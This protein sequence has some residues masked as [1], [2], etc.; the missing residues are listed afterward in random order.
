[1]SQTISLA[2]LC[3][4]KCDMGLEAVRSPRM[5]G[6]RN[7]LKIISFRDEHLDDA[8]AL[9]SNRFTQLRTQ[10]PL[11]PIRYTEASEFLSL[12]RDISTAS[13][14][15]VAAIRGG[16]LVG[17][18][19]G[20][21]MPSFRGQRST[22][23]PEWA[24][25]AEQRDSKQIYEE[26]YRYLAAEWVSAKFVAHYISVFPNDSEVVRALHWMGFGMTAVDA[27]RG[28]ETIP[29]DDNDYEIRQADIEDLEDVMV[30]EEALWQHVRG[31]PDFLFRER[32]SRSHYGEWIRDPEKSV[33]LALHNNEP[34]AFMSL[35]PA[36]EDVSRI[37]VDDKTTS[38]YAAF[39]KENIRGKGIAT[40]LLNYGL[41]LASEADYERCAVDFEPMNLEGSRFWL[42]HFNPV[43]F[44][45]LRNINE[46]LVGM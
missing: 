3:L 22:F 30:M 11:L 4:E 7:L 14:Y 21:L 10:E 27:I 23:S 38:I 43:C 46:K 32:M 26:M 19:T 6:D 5:V 17:F 40:A 44:S 15:G 42:R 13:D 25:A 9:V 31:S 2:V 12:L 24:N 8:A 34:V 18:L 45:L 37:I 28:L 39:T 36:N 1:M 33:L 20:W 29:I 41:E 16:R 35:G